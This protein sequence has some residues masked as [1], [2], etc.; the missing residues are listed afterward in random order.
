MVYIIQLYIRK[1]LKILSRIIAPIINRNFVLKQNIQP[2]FLAADF[3]FS[4]NIDGDYL[5]FGVF[6][7]SSFIEAYEA[8]ETAKKWNKKKFNELSFENKQMAKD[9]F[10]S[11][12]KK[13]D[14]R[15]F[16]FDSFQGL[17]KEK[18]NDSE[19]PRFHEGRFKSSK[20]F[21]LNA[22]KLHNVNLSKV[23]VCEG[24]Y[25]ES[26]NK[27]LLEKYS[28][29]RASIIMVDCDLFSSTQAVLNF[30]IPL[31][32]NGTVIIFDDWFTY[33]AMKNKGQQKAVKEWLER[34]KNISLIEHARYG[35]SQISFIININVD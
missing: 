31:I 19:H 25:E 12:D 9:N 4:E 10:Q 18:N 8:C 6:K 35:K 3:V 26:L 1:L 34:N 5:E 20:E 22:C 14:I 15:Y 24:F 11:L 27:N 32:Q 7:G 29:T 16:A 13:N 2:I 23:F 21:F 28:L 33:K 17:P 30:I